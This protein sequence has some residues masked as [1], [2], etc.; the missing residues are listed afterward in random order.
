MFFMPRSP[1]HL[2]TLINVFLKDFTEVIIAPFIQLTI[3]CFNKESPERLRAMSDGL[4]KPWASAMLV[5]AWW[6]LLLAGLVPYRKSI[7]KQIFP[8]CSKQ[9]TWVID[10]LLPWSF[11][12]YL[13]RD[14]L[15]LSRFICLP[16]WVA[17][18][19]TAST[20]SLSCTT[21]ELLHLLCFQQGQ[22]VWGFWFGW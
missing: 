20:G 18:V 9:K 22:V 21:L 2:P 17:H 15:C 5:C 12:I 10:W 3:P 11:Y 19:T 1:L 13:Y 16:L 8:L 4:L 14:F 7:R 6:E